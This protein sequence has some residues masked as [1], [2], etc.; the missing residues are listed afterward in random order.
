MFDSASLSKMEDYKKEKE[1][2]LKRLLVRFCK[3]TNLRA[4]T[5]SQYL[6]T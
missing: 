3:A 4:F 5:I 6:V 1:K 2:E